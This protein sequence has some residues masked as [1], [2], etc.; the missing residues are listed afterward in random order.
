MRTSACRLFLGFFFATCLVLNSCSS[1]PA[2][3]ER[4]EAEYHYKMGTAFLSEGNLQ[5]AFVEF[6]ETLQLDADNKNALLSLGYIHLQ[7]QEFEKAKE[8]FMRAISV[9]P[10][11]SDAYTYLGIVHVKMRNWKEAVEPLKKALSDVI[12]KSPENAFYYLGISYYRLG[13]FDNAIDAFKNSIKRS[14]SSPQAYYGLSLTYNKTGRYGDAAAMIDQAIAIDP[15]F[16]GDKARFSNEM[17]QILTTA[18]G[19][20]ETDA[21]DY[22]EI[23]KY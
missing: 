3:N 22:L 10:K 1:V 13:R 19:E 2:Q 21:G 14:P 7:F 16:N 12:Y 20:D 4:K 18:K 8:L 5:A 9:D 23:M 6:Q 11:F 15:A 17:K